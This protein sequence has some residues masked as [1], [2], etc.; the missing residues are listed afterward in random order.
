MMRL[1]LL[2]WNRSPLQVLIAAFGGVLAGLL[3][4]GLLAFANESLRETASLDLRRVTIFTALSLGVLAANMLPELI[5]APLA[6]GVVAEMRRSLGRAVAATSLRNFETVGR[7]KILASFTED[8]H[9]IVMIASS[10]PQ[11]ITTATIL[12]ACFTYLYWL[13]PLA[14]L[15]IGPILIIGQILHVVGS[16]LQR[17]TQE[18]ARDAHDELGKRQDELLTGFKELKLNAPRRRAYFTRMFD[19][20]VDGVRRYGVRADIATAL[21]NNIGYAYVWVCL[22][23]ALFVLP[24][25]LGDPTATRG[26]VMIILYAGGILR[27]VADVAI[28]IVQAEISLKKLKDI[29]LEIVASDDDVEPFDQ[30]VKSGPTPSNQHRIVLDDAG[31]IY[32]GKPGDRAFAVGPV[33]LT[34]ESGRTLFVVGGNG[35]GKTT[36]AKLLTGLY[37]PDTGR[38]LWNGEPVT[39]ARAEAYRNLF[40]AI[41]LEFHVFERV[42]LHDEHD[43]DVRARKVLQQLQLEGVVDVRDGHFSTTSLSAGQR[44]RL[45]LLVA[46]L[47]DRPFYLFDEWAADQDPQFRAVFYQHVLPELV[48]RGKGVI[49]ITHD[50]RYF[51]LADEVVR[52]K[53][54]QLVPFVAAPPSA[55]TSEHRAVLVAEEP[56]EHD[57]PN[58][59]PT[60]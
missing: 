28:R 16:R 37:P 18:R 2:L 19:P 6:R 41:F 60:P 3:N 50:D 1:L 47:D 40:S 25:V 24:R 59:S 26:A 36:F 53:D 58:C 10:L 42:L 48:A 12:L 56:R 5:M 7:G 31:F 43:L 49:A 15:L 4:T 20:A 57:A 17:P 44:K 51:D 11:L 30:P 54:G 9:T 21:V 34:I 35:S 27:F 29:E 38:I 13:S 14:L 45:A 39:P 23:I 55:P 8:L 46:L 33:R 32:R 22:G 52:L